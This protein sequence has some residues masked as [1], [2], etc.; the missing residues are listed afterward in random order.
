MET[1][2]KP[3][4]SDDLYPYVETSETYAAQDMS[5]LDSQYNL[6]LQPMMGLPFAPPLW[7]LATQCI[8]TGFQ[9]A[10]MP[11]TVMSAILRRF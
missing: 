7:N 8:S 3:G 4:F 1:V 2:Q 6:A 11:F 5:S 10:L 9:L